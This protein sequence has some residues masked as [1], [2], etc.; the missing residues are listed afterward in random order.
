MNGCLQETAALAV[1]GALLTFQR[2]HAELD[3]E[4]EELIVLPLEESNPIEL[5]VF[6]LPCLTSFALCDD[7]LLAE[8]CYEEEEVTLI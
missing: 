8:P 3:L 4:T 5:H 1:L 6:H 7:Q 2:P